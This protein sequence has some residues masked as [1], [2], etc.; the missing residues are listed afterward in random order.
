MQVNV[1]DLPKI[2]KIEA[3]EMQLYWEQFFI[4]ADYREGLKARINKG[5]AAHM[6]ILLHHMVWGKPKETP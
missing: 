4:S 2:G 5:K 6:E 1:P 3:R